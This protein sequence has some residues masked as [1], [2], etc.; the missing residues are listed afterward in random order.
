MD[1][2]TPRGGEVLGDPK[3][4]YKIQPEKRNQKFEKFGERIQCTEFFAN[5][6]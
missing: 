4:G 6:V 2:R 1:H 3:K 5:S